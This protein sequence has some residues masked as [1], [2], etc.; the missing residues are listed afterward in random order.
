MPLSQFLKGGSRPRSSDPAGHHH[1]SRGAS[2]SRSDSVTG[3][4]DRR[5]EHHKVW[6]EQEAIRRQD[7]QAEEA[8]RR[9]QAAN[10]ARHF[11]S[12][13]SAAMS[14]PRNPLGLP[15]TSIAGMITA[16]AV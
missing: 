10:L 3:L 16:P 11:Q 12:Q 14:D 1:D 13:R 9:D 6:R 7:Q 4:D 15:P 5:Q 8:I 2:L